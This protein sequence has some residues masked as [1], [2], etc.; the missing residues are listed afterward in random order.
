MIRPAWRE[1]SFGEKAIILHGKDKIAPI[2]VVNRN[3]SDFFNDEYFLA[4]KILDCA[5]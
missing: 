4:Y 1:M 5:W 2:R 3:D